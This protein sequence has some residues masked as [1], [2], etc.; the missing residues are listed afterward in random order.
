MFPRL[1]TPD[2]SIDLYREGY[3]FVSRRC[4]R[5]GTDGFRTRFLLR[6]VTCIRGAQAARLF[7]G[8]ER[9]T[10]QGAFPKSVMHLLQDEGSV[11]SLGGAAHRHRKA[12]FLQTLQG[13]DPMDLEGIFERERRAAV[14]RWQ[15]KERVVLH[16]E[17]EEILTR[18]A[19]AWAGVPMSERDVRLRTR[20]LS[21]MVSNAGSFGPSNWWARALRNRSELWS[22]DL[23]KRV[24]AGELRPPDESFLAVLAATGSPTA[25]SWTWRSRASSY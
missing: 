17:T 15:Q 8:G 5:L 2:S 14:S 23:V 21:A 4:D 7:Y 25:G 20:E 9:F 13:E 11:Q 18:T 22:R 1:K 16:D 3:T 10:R 24:R 6:P 19:A 12:M